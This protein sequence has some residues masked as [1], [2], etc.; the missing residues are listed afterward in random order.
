[1][2]CE[3]LQGYH[4]CVTQ[5][6]LGANKHSLV[7]D[8][9]RFVEKERQRGRETWIKEAGSSVKSKRWLI[10]QRRMSSNNVKRAFVGEDPVCLLPNNKE[11]KF[12]RMRF[13]AL[14][15]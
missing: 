8:M 5:T 4:G 12:K 10:R 15:H 6:R 9:T 3:T 7:I 1:M 13:G 11:K 14:K 2:E